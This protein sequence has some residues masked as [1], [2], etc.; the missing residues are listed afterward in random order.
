MRSDEEAVQTERMWSDFFASCNTSI[1]NGGDV[2]HLK[3]IAEKLSDTTCESAP[4]ISY[5]TLL[6]KMGVPVEKVISKLTRGRQ[7]AH[8]N[9]I[10]ISGATDV[11]TSSTP[12]MFTHSILSATRLHFYHDEFHIFMELVLREILLQPL[13][14]LTFESPVALEDSDECIFEKRDGEIKLCLGMRILNTESCVAIAC[15]SYFDLISLSD[16]PIC[17]VTQCKMM[18]TMRSILALNVNAARMI[19]PHQYIITEGN[20][21]STRRRVSHL[22]LDTVMSSCNTTNIVAFVDTFYKILQDMLDMGDSRL[23][24]KRTRQQRSRDLDCRTSTAQR[25]L[26]DYLFNIAFQKV[27]LVMCCCSHWIPFILSHLS[28]AM[29]LSHLQTNNTDYDVE[30]HSIMHST[31]FLQK[32]CC[33]LS[34]ASSNS[35]ESCDSEERFTSK[36]E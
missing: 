31:E 20:D 9:E 33:I 17:P 3:Q 8:L 25:K 1:E 10:I 29:P 7:Q 19:W 5:F 11:D 2:R 27:R 18:D 4:T 22:P 32:C 13:L 28:S 30:K 6:N 21:N 16:P 12:A 36:G 23:T 34:F 15:K 26:S 35:F 24:H 14:H